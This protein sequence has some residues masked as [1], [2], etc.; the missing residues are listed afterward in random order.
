MIVKLQFPA[1]IRGVPVV[2]PRA[3]DPRFLI[4][5]FFAPF[6]YYALSTPGFARHPLFFLAASLT[7]VVA[8]LVFG[9]WNSGKFIVPLSGLVS[10]M[11][12][13]L[14]TDSPFLWAYLL[15]AFLTI[16][17]KQ[18]LRYNDRHIFNPNNFGAVICALAFP[19]DISIAPHRWGGG[20]SLT[21]AL[22]ILGFIIAYKVRRH[23]LCLSYYVFFVVGAAVRAFMYNLETFKV[24]IPLWGPGTQLFIFYMISDPKTTPYGNKKQ[25]TFAAVLVFLD[26]FMRQIQVKNSNLYALFIVCFLYFIYRLFMEERRV[27]EPWPGG[28]KT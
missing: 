20:L 5:I 1:S 18:F 23:V 22:T 10:S 24:L 25:I 14:L 7:C 2:Y 4:L 8:D 6:I 16:G 19:Q 27:W 11:G 13:F 15:C 21:I 3:N 12:V 26:H 28:L 17:S 9:Y